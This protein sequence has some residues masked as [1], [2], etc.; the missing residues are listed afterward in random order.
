MN[1]DVIASGVNPF[2]HFIEKGRQ[3]G[4]LPCHQSGRPPHLHMM[5]NPSLTTALDVRGRNGLFDSLFRRLK[6]CSTPSPHVYNAE[7]L[8][9]LLMLTLER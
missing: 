6:P 8:G 4:R 7:E 2:R 5:Y 3:E 1:K 9:R